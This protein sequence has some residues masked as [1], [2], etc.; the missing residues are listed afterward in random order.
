M[1]SG[2]SRSAA[3]SE[4][5]VLPYRSMNLNLGSLISAAG[6]QNFNGSVNVMFEYSGKPKSLLMATGSVDQ[7]NTYVFEVHPQGILDSVAKTLS[8]WSIADGDDTMI[9]LWNPADEAQDLVF[10]L[11]FSSGHYNLPVHL[12]PKVTQMFNISEIVHNQVADAEGNIIPASAREGSAEIAGPKGENE[13]ILISMDAGI[14]NVQKA[15]CGQQYCITCQG[16]VDSWVSPAPYA[17]GVGGQSQLTFTTQYH[18]GTQYNLTTAASWSS[19]N[20]G[21]ATVSTGMVAGVS[22]GSANML[23]DDQNTPDYFHACY[24]SNTDLACPMV[25]DVQASGPGG[26]APNLSLSPPLWYFGQGV[27]PPQSFTLG[28]TQ[29]VITASG[30]SG[31]SFSW[32]VTNGANKV[33]FSSGTQN[34]NTTTAGNTVTVYSIGFSTTAN[35][36]TVQLSWTPQGGS[37]VTSSLNLSVDSPYKLASTGSTSDQSASNCNVPASPGSHGWQSLVPYKML[38]FFG[39]TITNMYIN[40]AFASWTDVYIGNNWA[41]P[42]ACGDGDCILSTS[43]TF[44]DNLCAVSQGT[45]PSLPPQSP[46]STVQIDYAS[47]IWFVGSATSGAGVEVQTNTLTRYQDH[48]RHSNVVSP[49]R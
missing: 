41:P 24:G 9:N 29:S 17:V 47:Q 6:L 39:A 3:L 48:G 23:A 34:S 7:K 43:G 5:T 49:V 2:M 16:A 33:S 12:G 1:Q 28:N 20:T 38:S 22:P 46:L 8:Y 31:G 15:T 18:S 11:F 27:M 32:T 44:V 4:F 21:V 36:V 42:G 13:H 40:E 35:D 30:A 37:A 19:S 25:Q 14:Y 26:V 45:P 10:T